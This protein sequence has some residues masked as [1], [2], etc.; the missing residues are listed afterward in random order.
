M[1]TV[2]NTLHTLAHSTIVCQ[3]ISDSCTSVINLHK[4]LQKRLLLFFNNV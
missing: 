2:R 3:I 1:K 4:S